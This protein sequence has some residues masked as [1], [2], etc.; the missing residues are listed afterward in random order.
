MS[1]RPPDDHVIDHGEIYA[2]C[3]R[4]YGKP[5]DLAVKSTLNPKSRKDFGFSDNYVPDPVNCRK[6]LWDE[7]GVAPDNWDAILEGGQK[8]KRNHDFPVGIGLARELD[9]NMAVRS[10][11]ASFGASVRDQNG[12]PV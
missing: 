3:E 8:L 9:T 1:G 5:L 4:K 10:M 2:A 11:L 7:V 12:V 6:D